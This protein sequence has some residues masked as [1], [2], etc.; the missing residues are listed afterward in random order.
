M[1]LRQLEYL[2]TVAEEANFTRAAERLHVAQPAVSAQLLK[3][4]RELGQPLLDRTRRTI[5]TTAAGDATL[6]SAIQ[7]GQHLHTSVRA[8]LPHGFDAS[9]L[10]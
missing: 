3:L 1:E 5:R 10:T 7:D 8:L 4:E 9:S 6:T 2:I